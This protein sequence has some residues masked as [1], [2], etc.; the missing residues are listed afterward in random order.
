MMYGSTNIKS[1]VWYFVFQQRCWLHSSARALC[2]LVQRAIHRNQDS[3]IYIHTHT[4][5]HNSTIGNP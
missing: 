3:Y 5:T 2:L 4:H 1:F